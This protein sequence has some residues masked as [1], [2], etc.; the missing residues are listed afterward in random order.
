METHNERVQ[1]YLAEGTRKARFVGIPPDGEASYC[2]AYLAQKLAYIER[3]R[4]FKFTQREQEKLADW[5]AHNEDYARDVL[6]DLTLRSLT[7][8]LREGEF[9]L[10]EAL[11][12]K[13]TVAMIE[14][15]ESQDREPDHHLDDDTRERARDL[16]RDAEWLG[17][18]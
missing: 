15:L 10:G 12:R 11:M 18:C 2:A 14:D 5:V 4:I 1:F 6:N 8:L 16:V 3:D 13:L 17:V 9:A 7:D